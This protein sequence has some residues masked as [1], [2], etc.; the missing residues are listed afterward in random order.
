M[1]RRWFAALATAAFLYIA[2]PLIFPVAMGAVMAVLLLPWLE[3]L[4]KRKLSTG[5]ASA[6]LTVGVSFLILLPLSVVSVLGVKAAAHQ[7]HQWKASPGFQQ[8]K[9]GMTEIGLTETGWVESILSSPRLQKPMTWLTDWLP[10]SIQDL[11]DVT[12]EASKNLG[13]RAT[14]LVGSLL[15]QVPGLLTGLAIV[16][17]S[18]Y[19][20]LADGRSLVL[21]LRRHSIFDEKQ[22]DRLLDSLAG[23]CRSVILASVVSGGSQALIEVLFCLVTQ[24]PNAALIGLLVFLGSFVPLIGA[25]PITLGVALQAFLAGQNVS[26]VVLLFAAIVVGAVDNLI[27]PWFLRGAGNLHPLLAFVAAFGGLQTLGFV[28]VFLGPIVA[29]LFLVTTEIVLEERSLANEPPSGG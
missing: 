8:S 10:I 27:R 4:E 6:L 9:I 15:A 25:A 5:M 26:G 16:V 24:T 20:F 18:I 23:M 3:R 28:G 7:L 13:A 17:V 22:T 12:L 1:S 21:Y 11:A 19:F 2:Y 14:E 29:A